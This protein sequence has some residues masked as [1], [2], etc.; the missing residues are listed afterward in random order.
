MA[1]GLSMADEE[2]VKRL[3][4]EL[5]MRCKLTNDDF[6]PVIHIDVPMPIGYASMELAKQL[7]LLEPFGVGNPKPLF[8]QKGICFLSGV[9]F[10]K[11]KQY[12]RFRIRTPEGEIGEMIYFGEPE[13]FVAALDEKYGV[14]SGQK[15]FAEG[16]EFKMDVVYQLGR[17]TYKGRD[18]LQFIIQSFC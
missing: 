10:G 3:R 1:A 2:D 11:K 18:E 6:V 7:E 16:G 13:K 15:L 12:A 4:S 9:A 14:G 5:N 8:A 17:N